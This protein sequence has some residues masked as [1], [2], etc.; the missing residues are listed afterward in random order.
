MGEYRFVTPTVLV[1][2]PKAAF[3]VVS[4]L[5]VEV[6]HAMPLPVVSVVHPAGS[7]GAVT[8]SKFSWNKVDNGSCV[9]SNGELD[10]PLPT[11]LLGKEPSSRVV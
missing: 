10:T 11:F 7:A 5:L 2:G 9:E 4:G 3:G 8:P 1:S 6:V